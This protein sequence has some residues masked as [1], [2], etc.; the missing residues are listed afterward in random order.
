MMVMPGQLLSIKSRYGD[1]LQFSCGSETA[2]A[3]ALHFDSVTTAA[4]FLQQHFPD[5]QN[6][7]S[8]LAE[9]YSWFHTGRVDIQLL[10]GR[11]QMYQALAQAVV[12]TR[13]RIQVSKTAER[14]QEA[15]PAT[16][17]TAKPVT[18]AHKPGGADVNNKAASATKKKDAINSSVGKNAAGTTAPAN[19]DTAFCGDPV[20]MCSGEEILEL[21]DFSLPGPLPLQFK[22]TYRSG[23]SH[24]N[25][26]MGYGWRSN[27]HLQISQ[28][29]SA[30]P[31]PELILHDDEG[32]C[33]AF[34]PVEPGQTSYQLREGL[35][36]RHEANGSQVLLRPDNTHWVFVPV[37]EP[38][39]Q[40]RRWALHQVFDS[41][42]N[43]LQLYYDR[44][45]RLSR[46]DY[47]RTR[48]IELNYNSEGLL[49]HIVAVELTGQGVKSLDVQLAKYQFDHNQDLIAATDI[50][51]QTEHYGYQ[52]HLLAVRQRA[53]GF[54]HYFSWQ[55]EGPAARCLRN[56]GDDGYYDY[57]FTYDDEQK[58]TLS[59]D[60]RGQQWQYVHNDANQLIKKVAPDGATWLY[61]WNSFGK[62]SAET[63]P[64][65]GV[66]RYYFNEHGQLA[67]IEQADGAISHFHYN[68][69]GQRTGFT[70][71]EG[72]RW[73]REFSAAGLLKSET[74][75][76]GSVSRYQYNH[77]GQLSQLIHADGSVEQL[78]WNDDGML[79]ARKHGEA[80]SR[81]S[82]DKL[83]RLN[84]SVGA[85][86][87]VTEYQRD[88]AG[89]LINQRQY[90]E[91][92]PDNVISEQCVYDKGG[93]LIEKQDAC[94]TLTQWLYEGL[95]QPVS[96][97]MSDGSSLNYV[98]D[99]ERNLTAIMRS[100]GARYQLDY[101]GLERP[102]RLQGFDGREQQFQYDVNGNLISVADGRERQIK[103]KRDKRGRIVE[104]TALY[105]QQFSSNHFYYDKLG[106][107]LRAN[108][109]ARK[110]RFDYHANGQMSEHWQDDWRTL[111]RYD[112]AGRRI[113]TTLPDGTCVDFR[114]NEQG[115]LSQLALNQQP[116]LWRS[117]DAAGRETA[118]E[119]Q[120][121]L[122]LTQT[123]DAFNRLTAQQ[124]QAE[125]TQHHR[126]FN[127]SALHQL[128][129]VTD[130]R[131][132]ETQYQYNAL[133]QLIS[134]SQ[135]GESAQS[136]TLG[137][138]SFGNPQGDSVVVQH[139]RLLQY[140]G[141]QYQYDDVGNQIRAA[142]TG[143]RQQR[144]FNGFNQLSAVYTA[145]GTSAGD[146]T[147][148]EY[149]AFGRRS[150]KITTQGRTDFLWD[151]NQLIGE[152][153][154][155]EYCWYLYE[156]NNNKPLAL[157]RAG[158]L[159]FYQLDHLGTPLSLTDSNNNIVW[160][161]QYSVFGKA[162]LTVND[163][164]NP[165][166]FQGQ[167]F[168]AESGLHYNH[169]RYYDPETGRFISQ[170]P[171]GLLGGINH[172]QYAPN[173]I[174]WIDPLGL[175]AKEYSFE[176]LKNLAS[177][178]L[179]FSTTLNCA[180]FWG[181]PNMVVAQDWATLNNRMTL[182]QT[183]GG[184]FLDKLNLFGGS[185]GITAAQAKEIWDIA[186]KRF[187]ELASGEVNVFSTGAKRFSPFGER[188]WWKIEKPALMKNDKVTAILRRKKDGTP[189]MIGSVRKEDKNEPDR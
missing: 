118:R 157:F 60:S 84:G 29:H 138:D 73:L 114:Y 141:R 121:G 98:Y 129:S 117:F 123:F 41:L 152:Y 169:F 9:V 37:S 147:R 185:S 160:Q 61:S 3:T 44:Y 16:Y 52:G 131:C 91:A 135:G 6:G 104:Q 72:Q 142:T 1:V 80:V 25:I 67:T 151:G 137:W 62:K 189:S 81:F 122:L 27:F 24:E 57:K 124:W 155:G 8:L 128:L 146:V 182:E 140:H 48:G 177:E 59:T 63:A 18:K 170:D 40:Q 85:A 87:L 90:A 21:N 99:K 86:G 125:H 46:I 153:C 139:D 163:I 171:I 70:D 111:H 82:Y 134:K 120:T 92:E 107:P 65:G 178:R 77:N 100:D 23:Q 33:L 74:R 78:L 174:N 66:T 15:T 36:L 159:Y 133:D 130:N 50:S 183:K 101:D 172:Y 158:Q 102:V 184:M 71:A 88:Q 58:L 64:D 188:T 17:I 148:Y 35:A 150:A 30:K 69:L 115:K 28:N 45:N 14:Q 136:E 164:D 42:G 7:A 56:W 144:E 2:N 47:S 32:R 12:N 11:N 89:R 127:Y 49:S 97:I 106:R 19:A 95:S 154:Q 108:N 179:D 162:T 132:G 93:R 176:E 116:V 68:E 103:L 112:N 109:A 96:R 149:D 126:Q 187:A 83:G 13:L 181:T 75:P 113:N 4:A 161:A 186:S 156:P 31:E 10:A 168:D 54:K 165:L 43:T 145:T 166:R 110:L 5:S 26:G 180:V 94:N 76:D 55:G 34:T 51:G 173:H 22:R 105:Q 38:Q 20:A 167:Y 79:L 143:Q 39:G 119:Y 53:S 175:C